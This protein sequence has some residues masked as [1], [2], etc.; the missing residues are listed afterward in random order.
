MYWTV[1]WSVPCGSALVV[2]VAVVTPPDVDR[3]PAPSIVAAAGVPAKNSTSPV[4][5]A[6]PT[7]VGVTVAVNVSAWPTTDGLGVVATLTPVGCATTAATSWS[8]LP[9]RSLASPL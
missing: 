8:E 5:F 1:I 3:A 4:G 6:G 7:R 9:S 2:S